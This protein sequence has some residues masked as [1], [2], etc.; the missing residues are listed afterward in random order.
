MVRW[1]LYKVMGRYQA[2]TGVP[3]SLNDLAEATGLAHTVILFVANGRSTRVDLKTLNTLLDF[4]ADKVDPISVADLLEYE[5][6][7]PQP[8][9]S[10]Q[11]RRSK[12]NKEN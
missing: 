8:R 2:Q 1:S 3:M 12:V 9:R 4:F 10:E 5:P 6:G 11:R 7:I